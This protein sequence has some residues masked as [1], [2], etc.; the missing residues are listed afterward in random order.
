MLRETEI[1][2]NIGEKKAMTAQNNKAIS[3]VR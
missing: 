1:L 3:S 2:G